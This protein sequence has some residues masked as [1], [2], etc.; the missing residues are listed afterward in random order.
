MTKR[1]KYTFLLILT[2]VI[3]LT[4]FFD[5]NKSAFNEIITFISIAIG[6]SITSLSIIATS[7]F[8]KNL[9]NKESKKDNSKTL[10]HELVDDFQYSIYLFTST[11]CLILLLKFINLDEYNLRFWKIEIDFIEVLVN[12]CWSLTIISIY[13]FIKLFN[14]FSKYVIKSAKE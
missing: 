10:L 13:E 8:S 14:L 4:I 3:I 12:F 2:I 1:F 9:Y 6:F 5:T 7:K 11:I